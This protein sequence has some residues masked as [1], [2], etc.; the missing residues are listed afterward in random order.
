MPWWQKIHFLVLCTCSAPRSS[1]CGDIFFAQVKA[2]LL[3]EAF[4]DVW[5]YRLAVHASTALG[6]IVL[7]LGES[8]AAF[9]FAAS[10]DG[11]TTLLLNSLSVSW[12]RGEAAFG[13][14]DIVEAASL[15]LNG[16]DASG[17]M[18]SVGEAAYLLTA[19]NNISILNYDHGIPLWIGAAR[20]LGLVQSSRL[21]DDVAMANQLAHASVVDGISTA[22]EKDIKDAEALV[23]GIS[24]YLYG[25]L[26]WM[27]SPG[28][29][30][31]RAREWGGQSQFIRG[32]GCDCGTYNTGAYADV[33]IEAAH[34][35]FFYDC[36]WGLA[37][38]LGYYAP[39]EPRGTA[40][41]L[42]DTLSRWIIDP[43]YED[44]R[45]EIGIYID[46]NLVRWWQAYEYCNVSRSGRSPTCVNGIVFLPPR[47]LD[48][49][50]RCDE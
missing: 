46:E 40:P 23:L 21:E 20:H 29:D 49:Q 33:A 31:Y 50:V 44:T 3:P 14:A 16:A 45:S 1:A 30:S 35:F 9:H 27:T 24:T 22:F 4:S 43:D 5:A 19:T 12:L 11:A 47:Y 18:L 48:V 36:E 34:G 6:A 26:S 25:K 42:N 28:A 2:E 38:S 32:G 15:N 7:A 13:I 39:W 41:P 37:S 8:N 17:A 10:D